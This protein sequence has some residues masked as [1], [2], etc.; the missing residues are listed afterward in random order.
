MRAIYV[1][2]VARA[3][4]SRLARTAGTVLLVMPR[5]IESRC[6]ISRFAKNQRIE[7]DRHEDARTLISRLGISSLKFTSSIPI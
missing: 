3:G 5:L 6:L 4:A 2:H 1:I 7:R